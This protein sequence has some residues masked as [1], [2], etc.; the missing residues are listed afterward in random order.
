[1]EKF[2]YKHIIF[3]IKQILTA[4][5]ME[6]EVLINDLQDQLFTK[7]GFRLTFKEN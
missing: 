6:D 1:M 3:I 2:L 7:Y 5:Q 4:K